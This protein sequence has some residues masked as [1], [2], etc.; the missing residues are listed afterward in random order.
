GPPGGVGRGPGLREAQ[1][2]RVAETFAKQKP[3]CLIWAMGQTQFSV[4]T[5]NVRASCIL[6]LATGNVGGFGNGAN[7][8]RGHC[9][10]QGA[11]DLGLDIVTLPLYY[12]LFEGAWKH[13]S[14]V[15][16]VD[17]DWMLSRF[18]SKQIM[19]AP[20]IPSRVGSTRLCCQKTRSPRRTISRR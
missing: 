10:V 3:A 16:E 1:V 8:F 2:R 15:W 11:T 6:L 7:I 13:W 12:G 17:Y 20:G 4:G 18:D 5:A 9:N 14:R 19:E